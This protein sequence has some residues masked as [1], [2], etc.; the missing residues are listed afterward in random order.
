MSCDTAGHHVT[1]ILLGWYSIKREIRN[2]ETE[3]ET[4]NE[5][6]RVHHIVIED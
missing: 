1:L 3:T 6:T 4:G 5:E 2:E